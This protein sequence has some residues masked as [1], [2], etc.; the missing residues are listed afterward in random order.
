MSIRNRV[1]RE[2]IKVVDGK[3][4]TTR[5]DI[6][7]KD[8]IP[9]DGISFFPWGSNA[10]C[11]SCRYM[12]FIPYYGEQYMIDRICVRC[13]LLNTRENYVKM[14]AN[15]LSSAINLP[16]NIMINVLEY[17]PHNTYKR[18]KLHMENCCLCKKY[19]S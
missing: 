12:Y 11:S 4:K 5:S 6:N 8:W 3:L 18:L 13:K 2:V 1:T 7:K 15:H 14:V 17:L 16:M 10:T 9:L 19:I